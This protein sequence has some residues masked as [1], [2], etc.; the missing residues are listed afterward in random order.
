MRDWSDFGIDTKGKTVGEVK[1]ICP[2][3]SAYR[4]KKT[5]PCLNVNLEKGV[6]HC[7][8]CA[9]S[10][11]LH[12][13]EEM[14]SNPAATPLMFR[15]PVYRETPLPQKVLAWFSGRGITEKVL[16]RRR[17][18]YGPVYM[19]QLEQEVPAI[20]FPY[21]RQGEVIN[22]KYRDGQ[23]HFR[24]A[25][26][27]ER[28][29]YGLDDIQGSSV[30]IVE[31]ELDAMAVE[32]AGYTSVVSVPDGAPALN[33][34][35]YDTKFD[36][37][38]SAEAQLTS[39]QRIIIAVDNDAPGQKLAEELARRLKP[40]RCYRVQ[41]SSEC[42]D[43]N[44][45]LMSHGVQ[46]LKE[47]LDA[48]TPWPVRGIVA[49]SALRQAVD[50]MY[51]HG[52]P[53]GVSPGWTNLARYYTVRPGEMTIVTGIPSHGKSHFISAMMIELAR[54]HGWRSSIFSPENL[55][56]ERYTTQLLA[57]YIGLPF[58]GAPD[59][60]DPHTKD[61]G[62][63]WLDDHISFLM[64][65]DDAPTVERLLE[66]AQIQVYRQGI[67]ALVLDP[68]NEMDHTRPPQHT[69]TEYIS[70]ALTKIRHFARMHAV[71]VWVIAHPTKLHKVEKA[72]HEPQYPP[73]TPYDI[74][75]SANW[76]NKADNCL[77]IW[78]DVEANDHLVEIHVQK[79]RFREIGQI[80]I[81][82]LVFD[83]HC[84]RYYEPEVKDHA[85]TA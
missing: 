79:I 31:G 17:I 42:K 60:M 52:V 24:M 72:D 76:R 27:A 46:V 59:R 2:R 33:T 10:G 80:G 73:P 12:K 4:K 74:A 39:M 78:R 58:D 44:D 85:W 35:R 13:G 8:H 50:Y 32:M 28:I 48:A 15:K 56:L 70:H 40:E 75:G 81:V 63:D 47:C 34:K 36:F 55:P 30:I 57:Q 18:S 53:R 7:W 11:S 9:W 21:F 23:K 67:K 51:E 19:P 65:E 82:P 66:L 61:T 68:W 37:L 62:L 6:W 1:T 54:L 20:Q 69:E 83:P 5:Y 84:G 26:G 77:T 38:A 41:W 29:L 49:V 43:A 71:H 25:G 22:C 64:P 14:P 45:V 16:A 3:C